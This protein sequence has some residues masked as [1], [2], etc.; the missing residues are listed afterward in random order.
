[1][2]EKREKKTVSVG[3]IRKGAEMSL[4]VEVEQPRAPERKKM[5][6]RRAAI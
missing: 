1:M 6:S 5:I 2:R 3:V 4:N